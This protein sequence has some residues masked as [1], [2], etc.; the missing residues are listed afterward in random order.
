M[1]HERSGA[2][3]GGCVQSRRRSSDPARW[4]A[5]RRAIVKSCALL[6]LALAATR[7]EAQSSDAD[8]S[9]RLLRI[10]ALL[11]KEQP[12]ARTWKTSWMIAYGVLALGQG[13]LA[14]L[15]DDDAMR[16]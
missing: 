2:G 8:V 9:R 5:M 1:L 4:P 14:L 12:R 10:E 6:T 15:T 16:A 7:V 11:E 3:A 13:T